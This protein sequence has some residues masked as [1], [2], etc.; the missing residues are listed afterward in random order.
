MSSVHA[1]Q[2]L[3]GATFTP[4]RNPWL[5]NHIGSNLFRRQQ[6][7]GFSLDKM[8][9][10]L[11]IT[12]TIFIA[13]SLS[14]CASTNG[15]SAATGT[16]SKGRFTSRPL[17]TGNFDSKGRYQPSSE[18]RAQDCK[19]IRGKMGVRIVQLQRTGIVRDSSTLSRKFSGIFNGKGYGH[20]VRTEHR[21]DRAVLVAYN[22]L[23]AKK[24][25][26]TVDL[27][28]ELARPTAKPPKNK[29]TLNSQTR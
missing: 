22:D 17:K 4:F 5:Q 19:R 9:K 20:D 6:Y 16:T 15:N 1:A 11:A 21:R 25:C 28:K 2:C 12:A 27:D 24:N 23:L 14:S 10:V 29:A 3:H 26:P 7:N 13:L 8:H 18:E